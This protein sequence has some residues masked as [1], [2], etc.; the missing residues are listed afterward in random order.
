MINSILTLFVCFSFLGT[1]VRAQ[2]GGF[3][4]TDR[5]SFSAAARDLDQGHRGVL[6]G[7]QRPDPVEGRTGGGTIAYVRGSTEI[8]LIDPDGTSDRRLWTHPD[9]NEQLGIF[10]LAWKPDGTELAFSSAHE[11]TSSPYLADIYAIRPDGTGLR[12]ITNPPGRDGLARFPKG[13]VTVNV[14]NFQPRDVGPPSFILY[15]EGADE[16]QQVLIPAGSSKIVTFGS[17]ADLG[18]RPQMV[19]AMHGK[20]RWFVP[21]ADVVPGRNVR[22]P[23]FPIT[24]QGYEMHGAFRPVWRA[25]GSRISF[26]SG[27]CHVSSTSATPAAGTPAFNPFFAE[28]NPMGTCTWDWGPTPATANQVI[29]TENSSGGSNIFQMTEG[30]AHP[31]TKLTA[32]SD[33]DY[34][35]ATDLAWM[36]DGSGLL[37]ST[38]NTFRDSSNIFRY[39][40]ASKRTTQVTRMEK[41]FAR[42][43]SVSPDGRSVVFERCT[44]REK[45]EGCDLWTV[46]SDGS[47]ARLLVKNG[48]RP[49]WGR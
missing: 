48:Q 26:R 16:P 25:D 34:Q 8:R 47:G 6:A 17:V 32:F 39:D 43:F 49:A 13:S 36:P 29:Y 21:G 15:I 35:I 10:E 1:A 30:G 27:L 3:S 38:V 45:D 33:L 46:G 19:V 5:G 24:G 9:L 40:L 42:E 37:Y 7:P 23:M 11:A 22:A 14:S 20:F 4:F 44:D 18:G 28:K 12:R 2:N 41:E 31:G